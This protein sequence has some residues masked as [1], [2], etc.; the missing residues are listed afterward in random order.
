MLNKKIAS[1]ILLA[2]SISTIF[3]KKDPTKISKTEESYYEER[4]WEYPE[5]ILIKRLDEAYSITNDLINVGAII[6]SL[7]TTALIYE[8]IRSN[9]RNFDRASFTGSLLTGALIGIIT[10]KIVANIFNK[11]IKNERLVNILE[12][13]IQKYTPSTID[14]NP[15]S[16][17]PDYKKIIPKEL[18]KTFDILHK[19][20]QMFGRTCLEE[21]VTD[22]LKS[23]KSR[24]IYEEK[25]YKYKAKEK[26]KND[27]AQRIN[28]KLI[29]AAGFAMA[30]NNQPK[31]IIQQN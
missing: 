11:E 22:I 25:N 18:I 10:K 26:K 2:F 12:H 9:Y 30:G 28:E 7:V 16:F 19:E 13:F 5:R 3:A 23:I 31:V 21:N 6:I 17:D 15:D 20:Y 27:R 4:K 14:I 24:I 8:E 29:A 1:F